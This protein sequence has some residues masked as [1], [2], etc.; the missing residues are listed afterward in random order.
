MKEKND[1][2]PTNGDIR[3]SRACIIRFAIIVAMN[4]DIAWWS[5]A[6]GFDGV[7]RAWPAYSEIHFEWRN[8]NDRKYNVSHTTQSKRKG[9]KA[10]LKDKLNLG[11]VNI[12]YKTHYAHLKAL[13]KWA[14][15]NN[16]DYKIYSTTKIHSNL[17]YT[18]W[19]VLFTLTE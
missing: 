11:Y 19:D 6:Q 1:A 5:S 2:I 14:L 4:I 3:E 10:R 9:E 13:T 17:Y 18:F 7:R 15:Y 12:G 8:V 16:K